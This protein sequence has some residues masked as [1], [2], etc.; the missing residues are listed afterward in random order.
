MAASAKEGAR[1]EAAEEVGGP[2]R[3]ATRRDAATRG[4]FEEQFCL[5]K[6]RGGVAMTVYGVNRESTTLRCSPGEG[7][8]WRETE[9]GKGGNVNSR[10]HVQPCKSDLGGQCSPCKQAI[11]VRRRESIGSPLSLG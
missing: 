11:V 10:Q 7:G 1:E 9:E 8:D 3:G 6:K 2:E 5:A 4:N